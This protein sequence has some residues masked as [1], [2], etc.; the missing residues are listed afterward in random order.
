MQ[1]AVRA[2][3][4]LTT[5]QKER[6]LR[7]SEIQIDEVKPV[8]E[9]IIAR[10]RAGGDAELVKITS[11]I[12]GITL[13]AE[14]LKVSEDEFDRAHRALDSSV[15]DA[16]DFAVENVSRF[17]SHQVP[18][19]PVPVEVRPGVTATERATPIDR[20]ALYVPRGRGSFPSMLYMLAIPASLAGVRSV[21]ILTPPGENGEIDAACLYAASICGV[22]TVYRL[23]GAHGVAAVAYGTETV[24]PVDKIVGPGGTYVSA[25]KRMLSHIVD[26]GL[27]AGP[28]ESMIIADSTADAWTVALDLATEAEHG[29]DSAAL[30]VTPDS[31]LAS[32]VAEALGELIEEAPEPRRTF[33]RDVFSEYG[34]VI[35]VGSID[36]AVALANEYASEHLQIRTVDPHETAARITN[37]GEILLGRYTPFTLANYAAGANAVLPTGG[38]ARTWSSVSVR[39][40]MKYSS[41]VEIDNAGYDAMK[42]HVGRLAE[43]EGFPQHAAAL[44]RRAER[45]I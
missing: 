2:W 16:L 21:S 19:K 29:S 15:R 36:D 44:R 27:P 28:S 41:I 32:E 24:Q 1:I 45:G 5:E 17:H 9:A 30:L 20:V 14:K 43:Y 40:F 12:D 4:A 8:V 37:A 38:K 3:S 33:L 25:A 35:T 39:D 22:R 6:V 11:E 7:R 42:S 13:D 34:G 23:G 18:K 26:I 10:V 31:R